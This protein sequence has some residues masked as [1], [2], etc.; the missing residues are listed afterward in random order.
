MNVFVL[1]T[2]RTAS[3]TFAKAC[4][5]IKNFSY[6]HESLSDKLG[7][8]RLNYPE[9]HIEVDNRLSFYLGLL[10]RKYGDNALYI[11]L[12]RDIREV[13]ESFN[14]RW[15]GK[16]SIIFAYAY[17]VNYLC[18]ENL[19]DNQKLQVCL[20]YVNTTNANIELFLRDK[21]NVIEINLAT[22]I[23]NFKLFWKRIG[24]QGNIQNALEELSVKYNSSKE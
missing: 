9:N 12:H 24:A 5:H 23:D 21:T 6:G 8:E 2:G 20:D 22:I 10:D 7:D 13:A 11:H 18:I 17:A 4:S 15:Q 14:K 19:S 3:T 16:R 1:T